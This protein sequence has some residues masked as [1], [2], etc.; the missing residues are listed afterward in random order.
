MSGAGVSRALRPLAAAAGLFAASP[1][2]AA[3]ARHAHG[4][5]AA[6]FQTTG[7]TSSAQPSGARAASPASAT[8]MGSMDMGNMPG[9]QAAP[10]AQPVTRGPAA[11]IDMGAMQSGSTAPMKMGSMQGARPPADA[12]DPNAFADGYDNSTLPGFEKTDQLPVSMMLVDQLEFVSGN[13]GEGI[14][15]SGQF[16]R[17]SDKDKFWFRTQGLTTSRDG[18]DPQTGVEVLWWHAYSPFWGRTLGVRQDIGRGA[19]TWL[20]FGVDGLAPYWF[21]LEL[22]GYVSDN[23]N[24]SARLKGSYDML[25][26]NRLIM[27]PSVETNLFSKKREPRKLGSGVS[28]VELGLRLRYEIKRKFAPYIGFVW[29]RSFGDTARFKRLERDPVTER[30]LVA[31]L[32][33]WW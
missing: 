1:L 8:D 13:E 2:L 16:A 14:A 33:L 15:W 18:L 10:S 32:R 31:G 6:E 7:P 26:T 11:P 27:T 22:T 24:L 20:A 21:K 23:A 17:G 25:L 3:Q 9:D 19:H 30:R 29:E 12:R 5:T 28:N 4:A